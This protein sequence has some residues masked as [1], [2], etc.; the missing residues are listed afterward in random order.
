M[1][2]KRSLIKPM[3]N[4]LL[5]LGASLGLSAQ[6]VSSEP[7]HSY[8]VS[9]QDFQGVKLCN[10]VYIG[11]NQI[12]LYSGCQT[13]SFPGVGIPL[14]GGV[15]PISSGDPIVNQGLI[16]SVS[17]PTS[18]PD[19]I[20]NSMSS[21]ASLTPASSLPIGLGD[22]LSTPFDYSD[23]EY[24]YMINGTGM[25]SHIVFTD[26]NGVELPAV[27]IKR[28]VKNPYTGAQVIVA[29]RTVPE[30]VRALSLASL[31]QLESLE[32]LDG[33]P[34]QIVSRDASG[35]L[36]IEERELVAYSNCQ[37]SFP[38]PFEDIA[39]APDP[40]R[41]QIC[42]S[43]DNPFCGFSGQDNTTYGA[44]IVARL[45]N[46]NDVVVGY[47]SSSCQQYP[48]ASDHQR[49]ANLMDVK[50]Q[51]LQV[52]MAYDLGERDKLERPKLDITFFNESADQSFELSNVQLLLS[53]GFEL[54][55]N[56]CNTL[57]PGESCKAKL[58]VDVSDSVSLKNML[59]LTVND[60]PAGVYAAV[61]GIAH[62]FI[63]GDMG[64]LWKMN[65]WKKKGFFGSGVYTNADISRSPSM[66]R[67]RNLINPKSMTVVYR[68]TGD[69]T[70]GG[71]VHLMKQEMNNTSVLYMLNSVSTNLPGTDGH[72]VTKTIEIPVPGSY[73]VEIN[74]MLYPVN[75]ADEFDMEIARICF[76]DDC[77]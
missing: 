1:S 39:T 47:K 22:I 18:T 31:E 28:R 27:S 13:S 7:D 67:T 35:Q 21:S 2:L 20:S 72:W 71:F 11:G 29:I 55:S 69:S 49:W 36:D 38:F 48:S 52:A 15:L 68:L 8:V 75:E 46:G 62:R 65:G 41:R 56:S 16:G 4:G 44:P 50:S 74:R 70:H 61:Q 5:L 66:K 3:V 63:K 76:G 77:Q 42:L 33:Y 30:G 37:S 10:G 60:K 64:I 45:D 6:A 17:I 14:E 23:D 9:V 19:A 73:S 34:V 51:G 25:P 40:L 53:N 24:P 32:N 12:M 43:L 57:E 59:T 54:I 58:N 26:K